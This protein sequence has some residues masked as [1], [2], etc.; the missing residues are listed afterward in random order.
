M[1]EGGGAGTGQKWGGFLVGHPESMGEESGRLVQGLTHICGRAGGERT[2]TVLLC[3][4]FLQVMP[5]SN[6]DGYMRGGATLRRSAAGALRAMAEEAVELRAPALQ[7]TAVWAGRAQGDW[8]SPTMPPLIEWKEAAMEGVHSDDVQPVWEGDVWEPQ[9]P[10]LSI[11][12][13]RGRG[14]CVLALSNELE[15]ELREKMA[16]LRTCILDEE[17]I[18]WKGVQRLGQLYEPSRLEL[19]RHAKGKRKVP[20]LQHERHQYNLLYNEEEFRDLPPG[21]KEWYGGWDPLKELRSLA[22]QEIRAN[23]AE[24]LKEEKKYVPLRDR[25][26]GK[27]VHK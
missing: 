20:Y 27:S 5:Y 21:M 4:L 26:R 17:D 11:L 12:A 1:Q 16:V 18:A 25:L 3:F 23:V 8:K 24:C 19:E 7:G 13:P 15:G 22:R 9:V 2:C 14:P 6:G 10:E